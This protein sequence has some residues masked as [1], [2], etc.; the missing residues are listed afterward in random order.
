MNRE[1]EPAMRVSAF[2]QAMGLDVDH[3]SLLLESYD[4]HLA[5]GKAPCQGSAVSP[6]DHE[7]VTDPE[8]TSYRP[9]AE[10]LQLRLHQY[11]SAYE[12][13]EVRAF[14][15]YRQRSRDDI[16]MGVDA[17]AAKAEA[18]TGLY[19]ALSVHLGDGFRRSCDRFTPLDD[20]ALARWEAA[21]AE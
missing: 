8:G 10:A 5:G 20:D 3:L 18:G 13:I 14:G 4:L 1:T 12:A 15:D 9:L 21:N 16:D 19:V 17:L 6:L 11:E 2:A 7:H